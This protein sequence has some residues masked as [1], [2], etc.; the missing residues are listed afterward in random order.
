MLYL[1][2]FLAAANVAVIVAVA[3]LGWGGSLSLARRLGLSSIAG[4]I[5]LAAPG[6]AAAGSIGAGDALLFA[7]LLAYL[8]AAHGRR[9]FLTIDA[10]DGEADGRIGRP[11]A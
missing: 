6:R 4:G 1:A 5:I 8:L 3:A 7:G 2:G 11:R 10:F 9:L